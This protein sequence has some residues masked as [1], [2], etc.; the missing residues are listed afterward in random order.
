MKKR[1]KIW[2]IFLMLM[3]IITNISNAFSVGDLSGTTDS[4][5]IN[6]VSEEVEIFGNKLI[7]VVSTI[8]SVLSVI[9]IIVLGIKYMLGSVEEKA[10]Y[11]KTLVPFL[12]GAIFIFAASTIASIIY[13]IAIN[14]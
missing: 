9:V 14:L 11:K 7:T 10:T 4:D 2:L 6:N 3:L 8:G 13:N 5:Y 1:K 12:V